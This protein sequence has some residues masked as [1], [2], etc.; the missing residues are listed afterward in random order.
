MAGPKTEL[1]VFD[2][3]DSQAHPFPSRALVPPLPIPALQCS[4]CQTAEARILLC[5]AQAVPSC[6]YPEENAPFGTIT[7]LGLMAALALPEPQTGG[8]HYHFIP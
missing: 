8:T 6:P 4:H 5:S 3:R 7:C 1:A 2:K